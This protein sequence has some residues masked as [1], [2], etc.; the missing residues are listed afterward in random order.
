MADSTLQ[1]ALMDGQAIGARYRLAL[2]TQ[3]P[4]GI[5]GSQLG[6]RAGSSLEFK[7]HRDYQPGDDLRRIDWSAYARSDHLIVK[8]HREEVNPHLD[9]LIDGTCSM[10]L[11]QTDKSRATVALAALLATAASNAGFSHAAWITRSG[12]EPVPQGTLPPQAWTNIDFDATD[13]PDQAMLR[14][15]PRWRPRA[16][17]LFI[18][19]LLF[20]ADPLSILERLAHDAA[21]THVIQL[22]SRADI[23]PPQRGNIR[24]VDSE[25][26]LVREIFVDAPAEQRYRQAL[27]RHQQDWH[28]AARRVGATMTTLV[29]EDLLDSRRVDELLQA[30]LLEVS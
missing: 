20:P 23:D 6:Q 26:G 24:L 30:Q 1:Q 5:S 10:A 28:R 3:A 15:P 17:R 22:L 14:M 29:G 11:E 8:L 7:E 27:A 16:V 9:L 4:L 25:S 18:S 19:D 13:S 21:A 12:C 2:P